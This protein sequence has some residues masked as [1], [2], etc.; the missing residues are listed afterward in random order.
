MALICE[1]FW[2][3]H[4]DSLSPA[5]RPGNVCHPFINPST[6]SPNI[7]CIYCIDDHRH[8]PMPASKGDGYLLFRT[9]YLTLLRY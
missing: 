5:G 2:F 4:P 3:Y 7:L 1:E 9:V 8:G 6:K